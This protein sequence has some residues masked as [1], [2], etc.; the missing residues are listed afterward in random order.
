M[1]RHLKIRYGHGRIYKA[2]L[3]YK[4]SNTYVTQFQTA[5]TFAIDKFENAEYLGA[6]VK[7]MLQVVVSVALVHKEYTEDISMTN[8]NEYVGD[9]N[10]Q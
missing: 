9:A 1:C 5:K 2:W 4:L 8:A 3:L 7:A 10:N 6:E